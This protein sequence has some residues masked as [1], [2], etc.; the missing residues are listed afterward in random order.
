MTTAVLPVPR[1]AQALAKRERSAR[2]RALALAL[3]LLLFLVFTLLVPI[4]ALLMRAVQNP[5]VAQALPRTSQA[6]GAW[7]RKDTPPAAAIFAPFDAAATTDDSSTAMGTTTSVPSTTKPTAK[8]RGKGKE[9]TAFSMNCVARGSPS[10]P[11]F[12]RALASAASSR[13][14]LATRARRSAGVSL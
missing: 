8:P 1:L 4:G 14:S 11:A 13:R 9:P 6:L 10:S 2:A 3:P 12:A 7:D 5:E